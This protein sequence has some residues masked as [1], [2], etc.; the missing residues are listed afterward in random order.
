MWLSKISA[1]TDHF[2]YFL[3]SAVLGILQV[4]ASLFYADNSWMWK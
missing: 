2:A 4:A 3:F 1:V